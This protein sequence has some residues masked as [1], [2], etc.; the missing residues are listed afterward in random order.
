MGQRNL[1]EATVTTYTDTIRELWPHW[2]PTPGQ[3]T[4]WR[5]RLEGKNHSWVES[6]IRDH[7]SLDCPKDGV[8]IE[9]RL[10]K[11]LQRYAAIAEAGEASTRGRDRAGRFRASWIAERHGM[12]VRF[13]SQETFMTRGQALEHAMARGSDCD[14]SPVGCEDFIDEGKVMADDRRMRNEISKWPVEF[15]EAACVAALDM[16][17]GLTEAC[18]SADPMEWNRFTVGCVWAVGERRRK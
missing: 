11:V 13:S 4:E 12:P 15:L 9:P 1:T 3:A 6:A 14:T 18:V 10:S 5:T 2:R 16:P 17:I 8:F 7:Y